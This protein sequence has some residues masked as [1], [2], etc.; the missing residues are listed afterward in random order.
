M[1]SGVE[2]TEGTT[3]G[4]R[5]IGRCDCDFPGLN[6]LEDEVPS[7]GPSVDAAELN[8]RRD[9]VAGLPYPYCPRQ[10]GSCCC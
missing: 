8:E 7:G 3:R 6:S 9:A 1:S 10:S 5:R 2:S 4:G